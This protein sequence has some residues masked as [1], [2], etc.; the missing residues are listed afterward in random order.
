MRFRMMLM[1]K[2]KFSKWRLTGLIV[3]G[4]LGASV[5]GSG[6]ATTVRN[7][8]SRPREDPQRGVRRGDQRFGKSAKVLVLL[9]ESYQIMLDRADYLKTYNEQLNDLDIELRDY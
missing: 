3:S 1:N 8:L 6:C 7:R 9:E 2:T 4:D 5:L